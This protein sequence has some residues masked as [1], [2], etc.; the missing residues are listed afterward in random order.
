MAWIRVIGP[1]EAEGEL[2][3]FYDAQ[4]ASAEQRRRL[5][6]ATGED[7]TRGPAAG[8]LMSLNPGAARAYQAFSQAVNYGDGPLTQ[9]QRQMIAT[10]VSAANR[11]VY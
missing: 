8:N 7:W 1:Q 5:W 6:E 4:R 11:C 9:A 2:K 10:V 3:V